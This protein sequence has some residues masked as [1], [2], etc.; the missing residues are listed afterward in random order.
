MSGGCTKGALWRSQFADY[1]SHRCGHGARPF[2][3]RPHVVE[4][5]MMRRALTAPSMT[6]AITPFSVSIASP[7]AALTEVRHV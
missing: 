1:G 3:R 5:P 6:A 2:T 7:D 4:R